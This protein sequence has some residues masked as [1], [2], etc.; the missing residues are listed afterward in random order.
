MLSAMRTARLEAL[1]ARLREVLTANFILAGAVVHMTIV[2]RDLAAL[3]LFV[4]E[5]REDSEQ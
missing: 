3:P 5:L 4:G 1:D 2:G